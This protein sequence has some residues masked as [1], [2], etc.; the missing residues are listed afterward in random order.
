MFHLLLLRHLQLRHL[1][2]RHLQLRH[3]LHHL[4][5]P[6]RQLLELPPLELDIL[7]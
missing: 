6:Y 3:L 2:L 7:M 4:P 5:L 1:Q